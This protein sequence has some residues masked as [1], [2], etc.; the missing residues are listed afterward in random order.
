[1]R[2]KGMGDKMFW[3]IGVLGLGLLLGAIVLMVGSG[4]IGGGELSRNL[5]SPLSDLTAGLIG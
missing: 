5:M 3:E 2:R 1:M 4:I